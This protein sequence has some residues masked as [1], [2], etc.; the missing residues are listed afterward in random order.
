MDS[1]VAES[2]FTKQQKTDGTRLGRVAVV[3][4]LW[5]HVGKVDAFPEHVSSLQRASSVTAH[6]AM[7]IFA[8]T[9]H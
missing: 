1:H 2:H 9:F 3:S 7:F 6:H 5:H 4:T 8:V